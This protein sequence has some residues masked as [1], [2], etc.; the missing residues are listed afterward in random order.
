MAFDRLK[1]RLRYWLGHNR[2]AASLRDE[3][4]FHLDM[5]AAELMEA[6]MLEENARSAARRQ[7]GNLTQ[8]CEESRTTWIARWLSDLL[9]DIGFASRTF[10]K[11]PGFTALAVLSAAL[12]IGACTTIFGIANFALFRPLPVDQPSRLMSISRSS[13]E[14]PSG[15]Q[16]FSF[17]DIEDLRKARSFSG[18]TAFFPVLAATITAHG[19]PQRNW[20]SIVTANYFDVVRPG[21]VL[22]RG[23]D[24]A[25]DDKPG[26]TPAIVLS[27]NLWRTRF[28]GDPNIVGK[29]VEVNKL[30]TVVLGV[31]AAQFRGTELA[32]VSDFWV[33]FSMIHDFDLLRIGGDPLTNRKV[34]WVFAA[35]RLRDGASASEAIAESGVIG[36]RLRS[37]YP[38]SNKD[39]S[40]HVETAGRVNSGMRSMMVVFFSLLLA[41]TALVLLTACANVANLLLARASAR[42]KEIAT[43]LAV[44]AGR[45]RL[46]RQLLTESVLLAL[47]GGAGGFLIASWGADTLSRFHLPMSLPVDFSMSLDY[48]VLLFSV[49]LSVLTGVFFGLV[50]ALRATK[51]DL[52]AALKDEP[53]RVGGLRRLGLRNILV[54]AQVAVSMLLL[55]CSGLFLR[56][57]YSSHNMST[58]IANRNI[59]LLSFD[60][61]LNRYNDVQSRQLMKTVL[62]QAR[63]MRGIEAA[64]LT[65]FVPLGLIGDTESVVP[66]NKENSAKNEIDTDLYR[67][68]PGFFETLGIAFIQGED[69][70]PGI[71]Q[72]K[73]IVIINQA[74][75]NR[76]FPGQNPIG[77]SVTSGKTLLR[78]VGVVATAK[79]RTIG[80]EAHACMYLPVLDVFTSQSDFTGVTLMLRTHG[81]PAAYVTPARALIHRADPALA[82][83]DVHSLQTHLDNAL[84]VPRIAAL[85][86]GICGFMG[87]LISTVGIYGL[88][89]F[90]VARRTR[91]IGIRMALG[92]R[93]VQVL[94]MVLRQGLALTIVGCVIGVVLALLVSRVAESVLYGIS[95][96]DPLT[97]LL[98]P[99]FLGL[100]TVAAC[101]VPARRA[102]AL[103]PMTTVRHE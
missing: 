99:L 57:L 28:A 43:R 46:I 75:A 33:P 68:A 25:R 34:Q 89:S 102:A 22:G 74:L 14:A 41:V 47:L 20:G 11:Q 100:V 51:A 84:L 59:L 64:S 95:P 86:F 88:V 62:D 80:E 66:D 44:G 93:R 2:R 91:E 73:D 70:R 36:K 52:V 79:S 92:A 53:A 42:R 96:S 10:R 39:R 67:V 50:P 90:A 38:E 21:F 5:K 12:G 71:G 24:A 18:V 72:S 37:Q 94:G 1:R 32:L 87:L 101:L 49:G 54:I 40:F 4:Q 29:T 58:G 31:T 81:D 7:F 27:H 56:S 65:D 61:P 63:A 30:T 26:E 17:P 77:R 13:K 23:F 16:T 48:R 6:G 8:K 98:T 83:F 3:M 45:G 78:I 55:V 82:V 60:P 97:F 69:F 19:E 15:G 35:G 85:L 76:A 103:D 9:Q